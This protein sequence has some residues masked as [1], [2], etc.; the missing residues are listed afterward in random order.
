MTCF[1]C[2][3]NTCLGECELKIKAK[4]VSDLQQLLALKDLE[5]MRLREALSL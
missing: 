5:I 3:G 2:A 1:I 4:D